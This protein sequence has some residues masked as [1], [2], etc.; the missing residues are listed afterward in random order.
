MLQRNGE[1]LW[2]LLDD[3]PMD[4]NDAQQML[5]RLW[6]QRRP[7]DQQRAA[8]VLQAACSD[9][10]ELRGILVENRPLPANLRDTLRRFEADERIERS[11]QCAGVRCDCGR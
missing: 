1:R 2:L 6:P 4:W 11:L 10:D 5:A 8:Q 3:S 9:V 7:L